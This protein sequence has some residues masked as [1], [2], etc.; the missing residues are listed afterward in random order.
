MAP[1]RQRFDLILMDMQMPELDGYGATRE[2]RRR[3]LTLPIIALTA[4]AMAEDRVKCLAAGCTDYLTKP[5][6][7]DLLLGTIRDYLKMSV[8][9]PAATAASAPAELPDAA[10]ALRWSR[11][12]TVA[13]HFAPGG[14]EPTAESQAAS[15]GTGSAAGHRSRRRTCAARSARRRLFPRRIGSSGERVRLRPGHEG[16]PRRVH[17]RAAGQVAQIQHLL[18]EQNLAELRRAVHQL[19]GAGGGYGF[20]QITRWRLGGRRSEVRPGARFHSRTRGRAGRA[21]PAGAGLRGPA[22]SRRPNRP[23]ANPE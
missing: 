19:K 15:T 5:I 9:Q 1:E 13:M 21:G 2:L 4:H 8:A 6:D 10:D 12:P 22:E 17:R 16:G 11:R 18:Q 23:P 14:S 7:K 3:G 20:P